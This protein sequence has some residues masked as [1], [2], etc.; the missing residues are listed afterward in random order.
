MSGEFAKKFGCDPR[1]NPRARLR[2]LDAIEK[3]RKLLTSNKQADVNCEALMEDED[4]RRTL[5][6][7]ELEELIAPTVQ[8]FR[9][10]LE[11]AV[12]RSGKYIY[13]QT[14]VV[15]SAN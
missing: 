2:M 3:V 6:R 15:G 5:S 4:L 13:T 9:E 7:D 14:R 8:K 1:E 12:A 11:E 10:C